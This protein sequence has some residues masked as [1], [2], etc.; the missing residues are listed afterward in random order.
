MAA[1]LPEGYIVATSLRL[2]FYKKLSLAR[3]RAE[4]YEMYAELRDRFGEPPPEVRNLRDLVA[5]KIGLRDV[6]AL[7]LDAGPA[8]ISVEID[9]TTPLD[10]SRVLAMVRDSRGKMRLTSEMKLIV[11]LKPDESA[12]PLE[13]SRELV[14]QLLSMK[15][16]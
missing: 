14:D 16:S 9:R 6:R 8:A 1:Y 3:S 10:P 13:T 5:I 15:A 7:R 2:M 11:K 12:R 4:L